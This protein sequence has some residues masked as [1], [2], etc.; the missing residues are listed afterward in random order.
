MLGGTP[1]KIKTVDL[2]L[3]RAYASAVISGE[4]AA[5]DAPGSIKQLVSELMT[6]TK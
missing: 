4:K 5:E 3:A 6:Q 2:D 1:Y